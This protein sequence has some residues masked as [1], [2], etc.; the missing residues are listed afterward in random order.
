MFKIR[1]P[2]GLIESDPELKA[3][4][5][6]HEEVFAPICLTLIVVSILFLVVVFIFEVIKNG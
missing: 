4:V 6:F 5:R 3:K 2:L 1:D